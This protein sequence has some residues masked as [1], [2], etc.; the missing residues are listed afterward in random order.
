MPMPTANKFYRLHTA[1]ACS[2]YLSTL[3]YAWAW[4]C[5]T[6]LKYDSIEL[7]SR[8]G[9]LS[10]GSEE[11][12][13][14]FTWDQTR[15]T[16]AYTNSKKRCDLTVKASGSGSGGLGGFGFQEALGLHARWAG[17]FGCSGVRDAHSGLRACAPFQASRNGSRARGS[18]LQASGLSSLGFGL[19]GAGRVSLRVGLRNWPWP[20]T[21]LTSRAF[22]GE[23]LTFRASSAAKG[24]GGEGTRTKRRTW[25]HACV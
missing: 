11:V 24:R 17:G 23:C 6:Q 7:F 18:G 3:S 1:P 25:S 16:H 22:D 14:L 5:V 20:W 15:Y 10:L 9:R 13:Y 21:Y 2:T 19:W 4:V 8:V 12:Q